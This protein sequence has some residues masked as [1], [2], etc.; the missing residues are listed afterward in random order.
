VNAVPYQWQ[1]LCK[2]VGVKHC[3]KEGADGLEILQPVHDL[4]FEALTEMMPS[5]RL[6]CL[7]RTGDVEKLCMGCKRLSHF[8]EIAETVS[9][10]TMLA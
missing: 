2:P 1:Q 6:R 3:Y 8:G 7:L 4:P 5:H 9:A 10:C